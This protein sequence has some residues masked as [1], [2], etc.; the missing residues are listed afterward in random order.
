MK[1]RAEGLQKRAATGDAQQLPPRTATRMAIGAEI[2]PAHPAMVS[3]IRIGADMVP[4]VD[5]TAASAHHD[6][7]R[8]WGCRGLWAGV[9]RVGTGIAVRSC[10][11]AR[12]GFRLAATRAPWSRVLW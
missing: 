5:L 6:D 12:K 8:G 9:A 4:G 10:G 11:E 2:T 3:T 1:N 7:A